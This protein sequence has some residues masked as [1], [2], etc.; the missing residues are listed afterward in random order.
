MEKYDELDRTKDQDP[1]NFLT[2][3]M[4]LQTHKWPAPRMIQDR[5]DW[6]NMET[7]SFLFGINR[8][9]NIGQGILLIARPLSAVPHSIPDSV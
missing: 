9:Q 7:Y 1:P 8:V 4:S 6:K 5:R 2:E 3:D